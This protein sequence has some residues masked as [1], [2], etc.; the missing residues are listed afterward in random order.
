MK[1]DRR[2][3]W[4]SL[5]LIVIALFAGIY[6]ARRSG[7][8]PTRYSNDFNVYY[9]A[10]SEVLAGHSPYD[11]SLGD[12]IPYLYPPLLAELMV[13]LALLPLP[14]AAYLWFLLNVAALVLA[15]GMATRLVAGEEPVSTRQLIALLSVFLLTR[16][17]LDNLDYGQVN[18]LVAALC[19]AH[20]YLYTRNRKLASAMM[21]V[22]AAS[23]KV[24]PILLIVYHLARRRFAF[25][26]SCLALLIVVTAVSFAP[27]A[28]E[29]PGAFT[30]FLHRSI[31]N[32]QG[33]NLAYHGNQSLRAALA[34]SLGA[35]AVTSLASPEVL[36]LSALFLAA[37]FVI[38]WRAR[39]ELLAVA[40]F[41]CLMVLLSPLSWKQHFVLFLLPIVCLSAAAIRKPRPPTK[42]LL[43]VALVLTFCLFNLTSPKLIGVAAA[44]W[45]D[46]SSLVFVGGCILFLTTSLLALKAAP[47]DA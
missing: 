4:L 33:F 36:F 17:I 18:L 45:C 30:T 39:C 7:T 40:P 3:I 27:F 11:H 6:F 14:A 25:A 20:I 32:E 5:S 2:H 13:P 15:L 21:L 37:A 10:A 34:R 24:T 31:K 42:V 9:F 28:G 26:C 41:F 16:F 12:W 43:R 29:S 19:V 44:E 47:K 38:A 46:A 35:D 22:F 23:I 1:M 8:D